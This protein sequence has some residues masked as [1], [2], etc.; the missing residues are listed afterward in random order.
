MLALSSVNGSNFRPN[1]LPKRMSTV[2]SESSKASPGAGV[3]RMCSAV[4]SA[5]LQL[6]LCDML[7]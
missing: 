5:V 6:K 1:G 3:L 4:P 7:E 2:D